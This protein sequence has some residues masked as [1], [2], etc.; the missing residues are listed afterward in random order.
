M[1]DFKLWLDARL[2]EVS[3]KS[4]VAEAI[5]YALSHWEGLTRFLGDGRIE[6]DSNTVKGTMRPIAHGRRK[7]I[8]ERLKASVEARALRQYV[9]IIVG[10]AEVAGIN[11]QAA[12]TPLVQ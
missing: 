7:Q 9:S 1:E 8:A 5:R 6:I 3:Q 10:Q 4:G 12:Q 2:E 11:L